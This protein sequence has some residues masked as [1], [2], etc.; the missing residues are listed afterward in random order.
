VITAFTILVSVEYK[1][2]QFITSPPAWLW[3]AKIS[4]VAVM[5]FGNYLGGELLMKYI[6][7]DFQSG[8]STR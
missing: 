8:N 7:K 6:S 5:L 2:P 1:N 4:L 3:G